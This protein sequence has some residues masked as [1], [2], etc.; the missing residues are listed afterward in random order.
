MTVFVTLDG[1]TYKS[2][3]TDEIGHV[4]LTEKVFGMMADMDRFKLELE[5]GDWLVIGKD[6]VQRAQFVFRK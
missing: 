5:N 2:K 4:E 1:E 3:A 6:A